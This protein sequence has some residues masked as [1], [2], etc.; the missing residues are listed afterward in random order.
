MVAIGAWN[1][2]QE[3]LSASPTKSAVLLT[4]IYFAVATF[5]ILHHEMWSD[6]FQAWLIARDSASII[7]LVKNIR[8]EGSGPLWYL[9]LYP[10]AHISHNPVSM[11]ILHVSI[12]SACVYLVTRYAPFAWY[13]K[14][15]LPLGYFFLFEYSL[16][17]RSYVLG[18]LLVFL[19]CAAYQHRKS[20]FVL[21]GLLALL[22][23][24]NVFSVVFSVALGIGLFADRIIGRGKV[25][26]RDESSASLE[27]SRSRKS[28][29]S[30]IRVTVGAVSFAVAVGACALFMVPPRDGY[31]SDWAS[32]FERRMT[33]Q[34]TNS[35]RD[36]TRATG[37]PLYSYVPIPATN[38][39]F[40]ETSIFRTDFSTLPYHWAA[41]SFAMFLSFLFCLRRA[42]FA[43]IS[44]ALG[45][46][47]VVAFSYLVLTGAMRH[48][49]QVY[50][51][52][53]A[54]LWIAGY[55]RT[56]KGAESSTKTTERP[57]K[58]SET[59]ERNANHSEMRVSSDQYS[60]ISSDEYS[61]NQVTRFGG[62]LFTAILVVQAGVGVFCYA[63]DV[64]H[65][66]SKS[67]ALVD[68]LKQRRWN[69]KPICIHAINGVGISALL[70][71]PV[72][73]FDHHRN[74]TFW[75]SRQLKPRMLAQDGVIDYSPDR[76]CILIT[77]KPL[78]VRHGL[79]IHFSKKFKGAIVPTQNRYLW[80][81][82]P[83][84]DLKTH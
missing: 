38:Y 57:I 64:K 2:L 19:F 4:L 29:A 14:L 82:S 10:L 80:V 48:F 20:V 68:Y 49:G 55:C 47:S 37:I 27:P 40:W 70:D 16:I 41:L 28:S 17:S 1:F 18:N 26:L 33:F 11:Q 42:P 32:A 77:N 44:Y 25:G 12:A 3:K 30:K 9:L 62:I 23:C 24:T 58:T 34:Q 8:Y 13:Q 72:Y 39:C 84:K 15:L 78:K 5:G 54:C 22:A 6:E 59:L 71:R 50:I 53:V 46:C 65:P 79:K 45:T 43:A 61:F 36:F 67:N 81:V 75:R 73:Q 63:L 52:L 76:P 51:L 56:T 21:Y 69:N 35:V 31:K 74:G 7:E 83:A 60:F 66:F